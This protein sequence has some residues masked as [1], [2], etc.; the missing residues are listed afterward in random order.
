MAT[1]NE[2]TKILLTFDESASEFILDAFDKVINDEGLVAEKKDSSQT[3]VTFEKRTLTKE[4]FGGIK[5]GSD[6]FIEDNIISLKRLI[7]N[8]INN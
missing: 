1:K 6:I 2:D 7:V 8:Q 3:V 5:H 4:S